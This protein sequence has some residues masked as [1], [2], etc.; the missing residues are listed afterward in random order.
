[1]T[2]SLARG[3]AQSGDATTAA[4]LRLLERNVRLGQHKLALRHW[5]MLRERRA[6]VPAHLVSYCEQARGR[7]SSRELAVI[8]SAVAA[9]VAM[10]S[11]RSRW[12]LHLQP[13]EAVH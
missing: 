8:E 11:P 9:W 5:L 2:A 7:C 6:S 1:M 10:C 12:W 13:S 4:L 3:A